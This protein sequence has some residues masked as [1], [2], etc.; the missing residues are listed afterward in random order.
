M[1]SGLVKS[2]VQSAQAADGSIVRRL[3]A[4]P[5]QEREPMLLALVRTEAAEV[6]G[7]SSPQA[8]AAGLAFKEAGFDSL[9]A[10]E[11]RNRLA[12]VTG[13][14]MSATLVYD[15]PTPR[16]LA[17]HLLAEL[18]LERSEARPSIDSAL[19]EVERIASAI[20]TRDRER[21]RVISRLRTLLSALDT[22]DSEQD[23]EL[24]SDDEMF[25]ILDTELGSL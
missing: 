14:R 21:E 22:S 6:L 19:E 1:L 12:S 11:M 9:A 18:A 25:K 10:V 8:V 13:L 20:D 5:E 17:A 4:L 16:E 23:L 24:A 15:Y 7:I 2:P 3:A